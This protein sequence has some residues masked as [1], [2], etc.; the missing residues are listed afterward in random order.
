M[1][2][3]RFILVFCVALATLLFGC[4]F[5]AAETAAYDILLGDIDQSGNLSAADARLAL[6]ASVNLDQ[7][8]EF[9]TILADVDLNGS[10]SAADAR[11]ILRASV[12]LEDIE[13]FQHLHK[14]SEPVFVDG[15]C[16]LPSYSETV[17]EICTMHQMLNLTPAT[18]HNWSDYLPDQNG[19]HAR[20]CLACE[21]TEQ[22]ACTLESVVT[23]ATCLT[24]GYTTG[25]CTVC[26]WETVTDK[27]AALGHNYQSQT[28]A[29][30]CTEAGGKLWQC[31]RCEE[32]YLTDSVAATGHTFAYLDIKGDCTT[33]SYKMEYCKNCD[34]SAKLN[35]VPAPGHNFSEWTKN[36]SGVYTRSCTNAGC[37]SAT[38][39]ATK[40]GTMEWFNNTVNTL[41]N[42]N[43]DE[44]KITIIRSTHSVN[45]TD[46]YEFGILMNPIVEPLMKGSLDSDTL[47]YTTPLINKSITNGAF[48]AM[49]RDYVSLLNENEVNSLTI[50]EN[51]TVNVLADFPSSFN[52]TKG[53]TTTKYDISKYK[54]TVIK[55]AVKVSIVTNTDTATLLSTNGNNNTYKYT[56]GSVTYDS[57]E[58]T[59]A[60]R[61]YGLS[62]DNLC[63]KF[64]QRQV[65]TNGENGDTMTMLMNCRLATVNMAADWYFDA[66]TLQPVACLYK[67]SVCLDQSVGMTMESF[68]IDGTFDLNTTITYKYAY[69]FSDYYEE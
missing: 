61:F 35:V 40:K 24:D 28:I 64:P 60:A 51:Q 46:N 42:S 19:N 11:L 39:T 62:F 26:N 68:N 67:F 2:Y 36:A 7:L 66:Q 31:S 18:G 13:K 65:S 30:T 6:R 33:D 59:A 52:V 17:C 20:K 45:K 15:G 63:S 38:Q 9:K 4:I 47:E 23:N 1:K 16:T 43:Q 12:S 48:P 27:I 22:S 37:K 8:D 44:Q 55:N 69:L 21:A 41:K 50:T 14:N 54:N 5:A 57:G 25:H 3:A 34:Y 10:V 53:E 29:P 49:N 32:N 56:C 58:N